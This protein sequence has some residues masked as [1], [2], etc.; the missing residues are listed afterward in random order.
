MGM[1]A[2]LA[3]I[4]AHPRPC[5]GIGSGRDNLLA[6]HPTL[7]FTTLGAASILRPIEHEDEQRQSYD[8]QRYHCYDVADSCLVLFVRFAVA[9]AVGY[10]LHIAQLFRRL[11]VGALFVDTHCA[12]AQALAVV[13]L[14]KEGNHLVLDDTIAE[15]I[16][17]HAFDTR[18]CHDA[19]VVRIEYEAYEYARVASLASNAPSLE[20]LVAEVEHIHIADVA[21]RSHAEFHGGGVLQGLGAGV[22]ETHLLAG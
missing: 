16:G 1:P 11:A 6:H 4:G 22:Q 13:A 10:R 3:D 12:I 2:V 14:P 7:A 9:C 18:A 17:Q 19:D 5:M 20:E 15:C 21:E 8:R